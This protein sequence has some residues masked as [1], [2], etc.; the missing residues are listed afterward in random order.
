MVGQPLL[1]DIRSLNLAFLKLAQRLLAADFTGTATVLG[2][3]P[4]MAEKLLGLQE[5][6]CLVTSQ[7]NLLL[8]RIHFDDGVLAALLDGSLTKELAGG[9]SVALNA[10]VSVE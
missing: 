10:A 8:C 2:I 4:L 6:E 5:S 9:T 7:T 3:S 1:S